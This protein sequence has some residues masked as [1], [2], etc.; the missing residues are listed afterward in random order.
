MFLKVN[1]TTGWE[2]VL[3]PLQR[4]PLPSIVVFVVSFTSYA[5]ELLM[6]V[7]LMNLMKYVTL[8]L[9]VGLQGNGTCT[10]KHNHSFSR[11]MLFVFQGADSLTR[12]KAQGVMAGDSC[13][14]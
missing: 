9:G 13:C 3:F 6:S 4:R 7:Q 1:I 11:Y 14:P 10:E 8:L 12:N 2:R 5:A